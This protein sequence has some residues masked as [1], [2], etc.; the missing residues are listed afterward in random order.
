MAFKIKNPFVRV[1]LNDRV[2][3]V[4]HLAIGI[5]S[6][7]TL[8]SA[9]RMIQNQTKSK[10]LK[11]ILDG[12][13]IDLDNGVFLSTSLEKYHNVFGDLF[14]NIVRVGEASGTLTENL[15]Y[16]GDEMKKQNDLRKKV[17]GAMI[18]P[19]VVLCATVGIAGAMIVFVFPKILPVFAS[20]R[21]EL[22]ITTRILI[23]TADIVTKQGIYVVFG[24]IAFIVGW[25]LLLK[26]KSVRFVVHRVSITLPI[27]GKIMQSV[28]MAS[29]SRTLG[30]LLRSGIKIVEAVSIT[31][32]TTANLVYREELKHAADMVRTGEYMSK[33]FIKSPRLFPSI[34]VN[35]VSVGEETGNLTENLSYLAE[36]Y[37]NEVDDFVKNISSIIEPV[38]L[39]F[40]GIIVGFIAISIISPIYSITQSL[41]N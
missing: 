36:Y 22:P 17:R 6:G 14:I 25:W 5:K 38:L 31:A 29:I 28:N 7:M 27:F 2:L 8:L 13:S 35:M 15:N 39:L 32:E 21:V 40:M 19:I 9:I 23:R 18:Y 37:E 1:S 30:L 26:I 12:V 34:M 41:S 33:H 4:K 11:K 16:L 20:L 24:F 10:S 3:F